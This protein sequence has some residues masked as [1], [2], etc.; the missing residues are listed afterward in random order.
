VAACGEGPAVGDAVIGIL[1]SG[2]PNAFF[3]DH[4]ISSAPVGP[5]RPIP[6]G[7]RG[8]RYIGLRR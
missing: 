7:R 3:D 5:S 2:S 4:W 1:S 8:D 6:S